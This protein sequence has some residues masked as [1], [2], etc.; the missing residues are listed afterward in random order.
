MTAITLN[1]LAEEQLA[2]EARARDPVKLFIA[3]GL[4]VLTAIVAWG[5]V[6]SAI[7]MQKRSELGGL[8]AKWDKINDSAA[9][10]DFQRLNAYAEEILAA[11]HSR[12][13]IAPQ[14]ALVKDVVL[15]TVQLTQIDFALSI[16]DNAS[17]NSGDD[18]SGRH[19]KKVQRLV[20]RLNGKAFGAEPEL[21]VDRFLKALHSDPRFGPLVED[22]EL[23]A[24]G[25]VTD[26]DKAGVKREAANFSIECWFKEKKTK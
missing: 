3:I 8:Q 1:L 17:G 15:P 4:G 14:L 22:I 24:I 18:D 20:L 7:L 9:E 6:L 16:D 25:R 13:L 10:S 5:G 23:R 19:P 2:Q 12:V 11:N 26:A 21:E